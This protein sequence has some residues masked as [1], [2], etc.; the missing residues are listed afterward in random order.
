MTTPSGEPYQYGDD[1]VAARLEVDVPADAITNLSDLS[2]LTS[3]IRANMEATDKYNQNYVEYL[4]ELPNVI[5]Q[6]DSAQSRLFN[7]QAA[8]FGGGDRPVAPGDPFAGRDYGD[9]GTNFDGRAG[10]GRTP[11]RGVDQDALIDLARNNP[12]QVA[13]M[14]ADRGLDDYFDEGEASHLLPR[15][16][17]GPRPGS[18][19]AAQ[20]SGGGRPPSGPSSPRTALG[21][22]DD[23]GR[24]AGTTTGRQV[25]P[26]GTETQSER[27]AKRLLAEIEKGQD[28]RDPGQRAKDF[29]Q[30]IENSPLLNF[31]NNEGGI[32]GRGDMVGFAGG[33]A[34]LGQQKAEGYTAEA[35]RL[36]EQRDNLLSQAADVEATNPALAA[37]LTEQAAGIGAKASGMGRMM[38]LAKGAGLIGAGVAGVAGVNAAIQ[39]TGQT[40]HDIQGEGV[41]MGGGL[42][43]GIAFESQVRT[44]A[45]NP[46][47]STEQSRKIMQSALQTGYT[48]KEF[49]TMTEFM[50]ENLKK[51]NMDVSESTAL[52]QKNVLK[53]GQ[54]INALQAQLTGNV[55][56]AREGNLTT[57]QVNQQFGQ[58][59][60]Q[61]VDAGGGG[62][63]GGAA[64]QSLIASM[65][66]D[67][68]LR[69]SGATELANSAFNNMPMQA[70]LGR[71]LGLSG[72]VLPQDIPAHILSQE[73]GGDQLTRGLREVIKTRI[74]RYAVIFASPG[75]SDMDKS[76]AVTGAQAMLKS[77]GINW[78]RN[79]TVAAL[80]AIADGTW[81]EQTES[82]IE[83]AQQVS[84][85]DMQVIG[86]DQAL[87]GGVGSWIGGAAAKGWHSLTGNEEGQERADDKMA[88]AGTRVNRWGASWLTG[89]DTYVPEVLDQIAQEHYGSKLDEVEFINE[90]GDR[91]KI[92]NKRLRDEE[93]MKRVQSGDVE[94][95]IPGQEG[96]TPL[97]EWSSSR[98]DSLSS[99]SG[100]MFGIKVDLSDDAK[101]ALKIE[102]SGPNQEQRRADQGRGARNGPEA[103]MY[104]YGTQGG[105]N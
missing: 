94:V 88:A 76:V 30:G 13:N 23:D 54:D 41:Q 61:A 48:G 92:G 38:P 69:E 56:I 62:Q 40:I 51:M 80:V 78:N 91:E 11:S 10:S 16:A 42:R 1:T 44:M 105:G 70:A 25:T 59:S 72:Q 36:A 74:G 19:R 67:P 17:P 5:G 18:G 14:A 34:K 101:R 58:I 24:A 8:I 64:A 47:I 89:G 4:R 66:N 60:G 79:Q 26:E 103:G 29:G 33:L 39:K 3:D 2:R 37:Q 85:G 86:A 102:V 12:R 49:D 84:G 45:M 53:G 7:S 82:G 73:N 21:P 31:L 75:S 87:A 77:V 22:G 96:S 83:Q 27:A 15:P 9:G 63:E 6:V 20:F 35:A 104:G 43:E 90:K 81:D 52:L 32:R 68:I 97:G 100:N 57:D 55:A 65:A 46:F 71:E 93:F 28:S 50:A 95:V 98:D 99:G